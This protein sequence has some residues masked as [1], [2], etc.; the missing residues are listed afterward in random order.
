VKYLLDTDHIS[1]VQRR[2]SQEH[3]R[4]MA[5]IAQRPPGDCVMSVVSFHEQTRGAHNLINRARRAPE[6]ARGYA[7][8][9]DILGTY[10]PATVLSFDA[11]AIAVYFGL[12]AQ[13]VRVKAMDL[14]VAAI[15]L[16]HNLIVLTRNTSDFVRVP[17]LRVEDWT[18]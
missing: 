6:L 16:S 7:M 15:A 12:R 4:L 11:G 10:R 13:K 1:I 14:R 2:T 8:L 5:R 9:D 3:H 18:V 17:G